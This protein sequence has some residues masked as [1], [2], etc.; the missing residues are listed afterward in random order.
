ML[1]LEPHWR[2]PPAQ[3]AEPADF[4]VPQSEL[5]GYRT[6]T[7]GIPLNTPRPG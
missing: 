1:R 7:N 2:T 4:A 6:I 3:F 5:P